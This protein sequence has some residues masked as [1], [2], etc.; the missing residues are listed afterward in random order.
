LKYWSKSGEIGAR[1][2]M[3]SEFR[4]ARRTISIRLPGVTSIGSNID[5]A[6]A[7]A[8]SFSCGAR[9]CLFIE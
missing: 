3:F 9:S 1:Q 4:G 8:C 5:A 2:D 6:E 7:Q